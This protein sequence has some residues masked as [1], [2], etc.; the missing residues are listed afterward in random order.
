MAWIDREQYPF[1]PHY[2]DLSPGRMHYVDEG[3]GGGPSLEV[4]A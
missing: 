2:L 3:G 1:A 4:Q